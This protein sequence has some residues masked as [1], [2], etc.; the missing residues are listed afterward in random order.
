MLKTRSRK[1]ALAIMFGV[2]VFISK[3]ALPSPVDK[4]AIGFQ[5][6]FLALGS[7]RAR[8]KSN[9]SP[10]LGCKKA[11]HL[12]IRGFPSSSLPSGTT[13]KGYSAFRKHEA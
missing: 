2:A 7:L 8:Y 1:I 3:V 6:L 4:M 10:F 9:L 13:L 5:A 12:P 11:Y